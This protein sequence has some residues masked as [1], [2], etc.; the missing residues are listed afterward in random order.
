MVTPPVIVAGFEHIVS[1][2]DAA[3]RAGVDLVQV[4]QPDA[5][6]RA[7]FNLVCRCVEVA[8]GTRTRIVVNDR[9]DVALAAKADGVHLRASSMMASRVREVTGAGFL[10]GRSVHNAREAASVVREGGL[11]Y[12]VFGTTFPTDSK[13]GREA[14]GIGAL[15]E[16]VVS[17]S[18]PVLAIGGVTLDRIADLPT[19]GAAGFAAISFFDADGIDAAVAAARQEWTNHRTPNPEPRTSNLE[20]DR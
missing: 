2:V 7:L 20:L 4:R 1:R 19:T 15:A 16:V 3:V 18:V 5:E 9:L 6:G 8:R 13:P 14:A 11:D 17:V 10:V 12:L